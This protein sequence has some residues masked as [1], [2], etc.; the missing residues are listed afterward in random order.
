[1]QSCQE[2]PK[3]PG[4]SRLHVEDIRFPQSMSSAL[5]AFQF[6]S[7]MKDFLCQLFD[8]SS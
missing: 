5:E 3:G 4:P 8:L 2:S 6:A 7:L 1:M